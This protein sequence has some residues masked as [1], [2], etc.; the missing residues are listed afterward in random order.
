MTFNTKN[1]NILL[2][3]IFALIACVSLHAK[4]SSYI[5][6]ADKTKI[7]GE[8]NLYSKRNIIS[9]SYTKSD[10]K[11]KSKT[12]NPSN[13]FIVKKEPKEIVSPDFPAIPSSSLYLYAGKE[14]VVMVS[15]QR[16]GGCLSA[17]KT[18][19]ENTYP[20][21]KNSNIPL[22]FPEQRQKFSTT[23]IQCGILTSFS[24]NSPSVV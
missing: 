9:Q 21:I 14:L 15:Q 16:L 23:A 24:P 4:D 2:T 20:K 22:Y 3:G 18:T 17:S 11:I 1:V 10:T 8:E 12:T 5:F 19:R 7:Y 6:I 13:K